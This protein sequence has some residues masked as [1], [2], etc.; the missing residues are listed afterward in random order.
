MARWST[1]DFSFWTKFL[2]ETTSYKKKNI[3][4]YGQQEADII[5]IVKPITKYSK[6]ITNP[7]QI[8]YE[9]DKALFFANDKIK[10]LFGLIFH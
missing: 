9:L 3:R 2:N 1:C 8:K 4:T 7:K 10:G 5:K 6:M